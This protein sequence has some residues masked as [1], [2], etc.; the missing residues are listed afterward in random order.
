M[1]FLT[2]GPVTIDVSEA[3]EAEPDRIGK[4]ERTFAGNLLSSQRVVKKNFEFTAPLMTVAELNALLA[5]APD[6]SF[7]NWTGDAFGN[8]SIRFRVWYSQIEFNQDG[9]GFKRTPHIAL[10]QV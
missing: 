10:K 9:T 8:A 3:N 6:G 7:R 2:C 4:E 1:P 5:Q